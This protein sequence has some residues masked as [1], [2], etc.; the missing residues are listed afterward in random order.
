MNMARYG[1]E[2]PPEISLR[3]FNDMPIALLCGMTDKLASPEDYMWLRNELVLGNNCL[4]YKE[5]DM[6]HLAF[7][8]P[9]DK[10]IF[11][12]IFALVKRYNPLYKHDQNEMSGAQYEADAA[13]TINV[14]NMMMAK[15]TE[16]GIIKSY[17][18]HKIRL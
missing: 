15:E 16:T 7:L 2:T 8:M 3:T 5:Y 11:H 13:V 12:E 4:Y 1:S 10:T 14:A 9:A 6:G 17:H 18:E